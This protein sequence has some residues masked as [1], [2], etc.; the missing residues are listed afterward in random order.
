VLL[1]CGPAT[2]QGLNAV[3]IARDE[4]QAILISH[5][6]GD[7]FGGIPLFLLACLYED[8]R[9]APL[10]IAG[11]AGVERRVRD[12]A[13]AL[14]FAIESREWSF[15]ILFDE[16]A[17]GSETR[18]GPVAMRI[19][20]THHQADSCPH[21]LVVEAGGR[22][23]AYSGDTGWFDGLPQSVRGSDLFIC[24][25]TLSDAGFEYHLSLEEL[26]AH[27]TRFDVGR[28]V[29]T[30][31]GTAMREQRGPCGFDKAD[32]GLSIKL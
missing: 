5:Y 32:D 12:A 24:E 4:V 16:A 1:D 3:G 22:R 21:G 8:A 10:R 23:I 7:H 29:L 9:R 19:F 25:C 11:P 26:S 15:P 27:R 2:C 17:A 20:P 18:L 14:G 28:I 31:L 30:H 13:R 6:H